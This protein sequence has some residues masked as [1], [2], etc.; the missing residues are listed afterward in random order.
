MKMSQIRTAKI[1]AIAVV[2]T[3]VF[4]GLAFA[5]EETGEEDPQFLREMAQ[6]LR[7]DGWTEEEIEEFRTAAEK[8]NW[9][10]AEGADPE[11]VAKALQ[12]AN[13]DREQL[14]GSENADLA[15]ELAEMARN[16]EQAGF[17][18]REIARAAFDGTREVVDN[19]Q[20]MR[21]Q[22][23]QNEQA[24][25]GEA[26]EAGDMLQMRERIRDQI[27]EHLDVA[28][29]NRSRAMERAEK[30]KE[31]GRGKEKPEDTPG[32]GAGGPDNAPE[33]PAEGNRR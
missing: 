5:Q 19:M 14:E 13:Q 8:R 25:S 12:L 17:E 16:M 28:M 3:M 11:V 15:L 33:I 21:E 20:Q 1:T 18:G 30:A 31:A 10:E 27:R 22:A 7:Q 9:D 4:A 32:P 29:E 26:A 2:L 6:E 24:Q 23:R